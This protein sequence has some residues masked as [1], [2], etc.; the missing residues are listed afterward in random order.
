MDQQKTGQLI[1]QRRKELGLTQKQLAERISVSD[2]AISK[3]ERG[4]GFPDVSL[5]EG[6]ADALSL[7][8]LELFRGELHPEDDAPAREALHFALPQMMKKI[9]HYK[10]L[11]L[12]LPIL[13]LALMLF[14]LIPTAGNQWSAENSPIV[15]E[16]AT[17]IAPEILITAADFDLID[18]ILSD[19]ELG[20][21]Y[22]PYPLGQDVRHYVLENEEARDFT[23]YFDSLG[24]DL[25]Y[26]GIDI[27]G[28]TLTI[29]YST[30]AMSVYLT[31]TPDGIQKSVIIPEI[32]IWDEDGTMVPIGRRH[33]KRIDLENFNNEEFYRGGY[34]TGWLE[35]FRTTYY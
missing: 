9:R 34:T 20:Q 23:D 2:R 12:F 26:A 16:E 14:I 32:S 4:A 29:I 22:I 19:P 25:R 8:I 27:H 1:A 7:S 5:I 3:W 17:A 24:A 28:S 10:R 33:G 15:P 13:V 30:P 35:W 6:L 31:Y 11:S 18:T 21:Y